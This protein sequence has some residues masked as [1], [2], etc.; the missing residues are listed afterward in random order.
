[1]PVVDTSPASYVCSTSA[2]PLAE[3]TAKYGAEKAASMMA[4][5]QG[6]S[7]QASFAK[8]NYNFGLQWSGT[9]KFGCGAGFALFGIMYLFTIV[10]IVLDIF[11]RQA[12][13]EE[14]VVEDRKALSELGI[15]VNSL[16]GDLHKRLT[17]TGVEENADDQLIG[18]AA[19]LQQGQF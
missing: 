19:K 18:E 2:K 17:E 14:M 12:M 8:Q 4:I 9:Q 16:A 10:R 7:Q 6:C 13:Y 3:Y 1:M 15:D 5:Y 11:K